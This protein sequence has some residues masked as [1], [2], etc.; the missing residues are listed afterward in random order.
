MSFAKNDARDAEIVRRRQAGE[1]PRAI[2]RAMG[3]THNVVIGVCYRAGLSNQDNARKENLR[4]EQCPHAVLTEEAVR[5]IRRDFV[6]HLVTVPALAK[7][8][9]V[10]KRTIEY[11]LY[12]GGWAH[13]Q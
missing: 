9:G 11:I 7:R 6:P 3:L 10:H 1:W 13:V 4:G 12:A 8:F 5:T 2:A